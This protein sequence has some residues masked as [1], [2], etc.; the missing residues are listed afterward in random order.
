[1]AEVPQDIRI[2]ANW[3]NPFNSNTTINYE[4]IKPGNVKLTIYNLLGQE[5]VSLFTGYQQKGVYDI[6][7]NGQDKYG[8]PVANGSYY[9]R[10]ESGKSVVQRK[11]MVV[12]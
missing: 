3:P 7:W 8:L 6:Q 2:N 4:L 5:V 11:V 10:M 9:I 12:W 1:M